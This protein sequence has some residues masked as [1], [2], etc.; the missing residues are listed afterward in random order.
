VACSRVFQQHPSRLGEHVGQAVGGVA[1][2][3]VETVELAQL[4][5]FQWP[6]LRHV[7]R[8]GEKDIVHGRGGNCLHISLQ[9]FAVN[10]HAQH[11][12]ALL[13]RVFSAD[14]DNEVRDLPE[15]V[16][17]IAD[18]DTAALHFPVPDL[19][20]VVL[21]LE[22]VRAGVGFLDTSG[23]NDLYVDKIRVFLL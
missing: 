9:G 7:V 18:I 21:L 5:V 15:T 2:C 19:V 22:R 14:G 3:F 6:G 11:P 1:L 16:K 8:V 17:N 23:I 10:C 4:A 20:A 12:G 13:A